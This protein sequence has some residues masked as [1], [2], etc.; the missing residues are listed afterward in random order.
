VLWYR[1][2]VAWQT[3]WTSF[4]LSV[5]SRFQGPEALGIGLP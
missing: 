2:W 1:Q 5:F 3:M 4:S